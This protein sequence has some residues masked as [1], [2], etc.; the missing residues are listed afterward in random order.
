[1]T[2]NWEELLEAGA[3]AGRRGIAILRIVVEMLSFLVVG[4]AAAQ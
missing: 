3:V 1:V 2:L 4:L